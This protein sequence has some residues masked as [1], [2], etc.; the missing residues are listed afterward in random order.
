MVSP[1]ATP[2]SAH[3]SR[4][5]CELLGLTARV[6]RS[7]EIFGWLLTYKA[8]PA[9]MYIVTQKRHLPPPPTVP[10]AA[11]ARGPSMAPSDASDIDP[12]ALVAT[13][14]TGA[15][16]GAGAGDSGSGGG[17][18]I[19]LTKSSSLLT[20]ILW[21]MLDSDNVGIQSQAAEVL[22]LVVATETMT[23]GDQEQ[24]LTCF[25]DRYIMWLTQP[26]IGPGAEADSTRG[27]SCYARG[28]DA[29]NRSGTLTP[30]PPRVVALP[31]VVNAQSRV[32]E[33][34]RSG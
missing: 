15:G 7:L 22:R 18:Y 31:L 17:G 33:K 16:A 29:D 23:A 1:A 14:G 30:P 21:C 32:R 10:S 34:M 26:F 9:R 12:A 24:F 11:R 2:F 25:Y 4:S 28:D 13:A 8:T 19:R 27:T 5:W 20:R 3:V 6:L